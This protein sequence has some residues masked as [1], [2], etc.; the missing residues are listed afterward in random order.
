[1][2]F[3]PRLTSRKPAVAGRPRRRPTVRPS[4]ETLEDR[5]VP[6]ANFALAFAIGSTGNDVTS[7]VATDSAGDV[8]VS[9]SIRNDVVNFAT[10][11]G[12]VTIDATGSKYS[13]GYVAKYSPS[14]N[15]DWVQQTGIPDGGLAVDGSG[16][17]YDTSN[18][19]NTATHYLT[20]FDPNGNTLWATNLNSALGMGTVVQAAN[21]SGLALDGAGNAYLTGITPDGY[22]DY[23][24][25][26]NGSDGSLAW[27]VQHGTGNYY[28]DAPKIAVDPSGNV[29]TTGAYS[30]K[31]D[32]DPGPG[33]FYLTSYGSKKAGYTFDAYVVKLDPNGNFLWAGSMGTDK[34]AQCSAIA[35]DGAGN[36]YLTGVLVPSTG[37]SDFDPGPGVAPLSGGGTYVVKL[38][39]NDNFQWA[40]NYGGTTNP[41]VQSQRIAVDSAGAVYLT[42]YFSGPVDFDLGPG[43]YLLT[44][45]SSS[46][47]Y[48]LKLN[49]G[50]QFAWAAALNGNQ[51]DLGDSIAVDPMGDVYTVG[52]FQG[53]VDFD[54]GPG[55]YNLTS[56]GGLDG[57]VLKLTQSSP[58]L[59]AVSPSTASL[60]M[61]KSGPDSNPLLAAL[62]SQTGRAL[63]H[64]FAEGGSFSMS[65]WDTVALAIVLRKE[66][67]HTA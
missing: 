57:F 63:D 23:V 45:G 66:H 34:G 58:M 44:A 21:F 29:Y 50:G 47:V 62:T 32:F 48:V 15:L 35:V 41:A 51:S 56:N 8:I 31:A 7:K 40:E 20:K 17:V 55:T 37:Q 13:V 38:D 39:S 54:P 60:T 67:N 4:L 65:G 3:L 14:G 10:N 1:M 22:H 5:R 18:D 36:V 24:S 25:K 64:V 42:G 11:G 49:T 43:Q 52:Y 6:S 9:G 46:N 61:K 59:V 26:F 2:S 27:N 12:S 16:N 28:P 33:T 30:G 53:T 19:Q